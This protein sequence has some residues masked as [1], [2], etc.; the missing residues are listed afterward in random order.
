MQ[1]D[2]WRSIFLV[3]GRPAMKAIRILVA[4]LGGAASA[5][6]LWYL[7]PGFGSWRAPTLRALGAPGHRAPLSAVAL[8][9]DGRLAASADAAGRLL[10]WEVDTGRVDDRVGGPDRARALAFLADGSLGAADAAGDL[11]VWNR[12][13]ATAR[14]IDRATALARGGV[15]GRL[16]LSAAPGVTATVL[17]DPDRVAVGE[18]SGR[19]RL[20]GGEGTEA[21]LRETGPAPTALAFD[22]AAG[23]LAV[24][25]AGEIEMLALS[26]PVGRSVERRAW[27]G[28]AVV[29]LAFVSDGRLLAVEAGGGRLLLSAAGGGAAER[30]DPGGRLVRRTALSA[31]GARVVE[32]GDDGVLRFAAALRSGGLSRSLGAAARFVAVA[33]D[34][35][36]ASAH[37]SGPHRP[38]LVALWDGETGERIAAYDLGRSPSCVGFS[39]AGEV[40]VGLGRR[41]I[42]LAAD[43]SSSTGRGLDEPILDAGAARE[44][45]PEAGCGESRGGRFAIRL[46]EPAL[47]L[48][49]FLEDRRS[50]LYVPLGGRYLAG[51]VQRRSLRDLVG[52]RVPFVAIGRGGEV[53]LARAAPRFS[54]PLLLAGLWAAALGVSLARSA[55]KRP[56]RG[57]AS[58]PAEQEE[59]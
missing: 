21:V 49:T 33:A 5:A 6:L 42:A 4:L 18:R 13:S 24:A 1:P 17:V 41:R 59:P 47:G 22:R 50:G 48:E 11:A 27:A 44:L 32:A 3:H 10:L 45:P 34:G 51:A 28:E 19:I 7:P 14:P 2:P 53:V 57:E 43:R 52:G 58:R 12:G 35:T 46:F 25:A 20:V 56:P 8:S 55:R 36:L 23:R 26:G 37:G 15:L 9:A 16:A 29:G 40:V 31:D 30:L 39:P 38:G 54:L